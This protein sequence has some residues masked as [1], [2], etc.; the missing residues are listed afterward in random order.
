MNKKKMVED[1]EKLNK[2]I[3]QLCVQIY[4]KDETKNLLGELYFLCYF[5]IKVTILIIKQ[6]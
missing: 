5:L 1:T 2:M 4:Y 6:T 3:K